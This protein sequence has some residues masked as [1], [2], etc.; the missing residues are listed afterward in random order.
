MEGLAL[1]KSVDRLFSSGHAGCAVLARQLWS[2]KGNGEE[3]GLT[4]LEFPNRLRQIRNKRMLSLRG[5]ISARAAAEAT[6]PHHTVCVKRCVVIFIGRD[7]LLTQARE[8]FV[9]VTGLR[10]S[11]V[12]LRL[13]QPKTSLSLRHMRNTTE[14]HNGVVLVVVKHC[15]AFLCSDFH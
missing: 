2:G 10:F 14:A 8:Y 1:P 12:S 9:Q 11:A 15:N 5:G 4:K 6:D 3:A 7:P 13:A